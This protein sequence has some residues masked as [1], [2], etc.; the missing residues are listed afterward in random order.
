LERSAADR[1]VEGSIWLNRDV[2][3]RVVEGVESPALIATTAASSS[4]S[5]D[6]KCAPIGLTCRCAL[7]GHDGTVMTLELMTSVAVLLL[8]AAWLYHHFRAAWRQNRATLAAS[9]WSP[10][11][12]TGEC[13]AFFR[14]LERTD[15]L[16]GRLE[17][18]DRGGR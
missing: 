15:H 3:A 10:P 7:A 2:L 12:S 13:V 9:T 14:D 6:G 16:I 11:I 8:A 1:T 4:K 17:T 18:E 5:G